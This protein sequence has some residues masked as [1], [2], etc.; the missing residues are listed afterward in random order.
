MS[1]E[2][3]RT[4]AVEPASSTSVVFSEI[5]S[6]VVPATKDAGEGEAGT[7]MLLPK[8]LGLSRG[9]P[10]KLNLATPTQEKNVSYNFHL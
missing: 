8:G 5:P 6:L 3:Q 9:R 1:C 2:P 4:V 7:P 10:R